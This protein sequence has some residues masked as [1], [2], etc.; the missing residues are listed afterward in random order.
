MEILAT[1]CLN[2]SDAI[3]I[4][5]FPD[6]APKAVMSFILLARGRYYENI[7]FHKIVEDSYIQ[8]GDH[9]ETGY[10]SA[11]Y[12]FVDEHSDILLFDRPGVIGNAYLGQN[13]NGGQIIITLKP[14]ESFNNR[15][16][17]FGVVVNP[18]DIE[19]LKNVQVG[20]VINNIVIH[21]NFNEIRKKYTKDYDYFD[22]M[23][24]FE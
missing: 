11:G 13:K 16:T 17:A 2:T 6:I 12:E 3:K 15:N 4:K 23:I 9:T 14:M 20:D 5:L 21:G 22:E 24:Y 7:E 18:S 8:F 19:I 1:I 10:G